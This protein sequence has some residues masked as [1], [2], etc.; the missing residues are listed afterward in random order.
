[1]ADA[2][3]IGGVRVEPAKLT[4]SGYAF[5]YPDLDGALNHLFHINT[6]EK[7]QKGHGLIGHFFSRS[8]YGPP[9]CDQ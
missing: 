1:M 7:T 6:T 9:L 8:P 3:L 4:Q 2:L 5:R